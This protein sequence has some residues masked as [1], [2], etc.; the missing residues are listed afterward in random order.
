VSRIDEATVL[1]T[2]FERPAD[3]DLAAYW[4]PPG[5]RRSGRRQVMAKRKLQRRI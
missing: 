5:L 1:E 2:R 4:K 3:F